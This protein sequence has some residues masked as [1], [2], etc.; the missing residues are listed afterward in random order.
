MDV[1][2]KRKP[3]TILI[4]ELYVDLHLH[5]QLPCNCPEGG[6]SGVSVAYSDARVVDNGTV[7]VVFLV[8]LTFT[9]KCV[10]TLIAIETFARHSYDT[11]SCGSASTSAHKHT[12]TYG[13]YPTCVYTCD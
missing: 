13:S 2:C 1:V 10:I 9:L 6:A 3:N 11:I 12:R 4:A 5:M 8:V 7:E